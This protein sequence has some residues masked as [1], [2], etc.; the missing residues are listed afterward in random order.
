MHD[1]VYLSDFCLLSVFSL[2]TSF[3]P[4]RSLTL[5]P[6][7]YHLRAFALVSF[8]AWNTLFQDLYSASSSSS[9]RSQCHLL[10]WALCGIPLQVILHLPPQS[11]IRDLISFTPLVSVCHDHVYFLVFSLNIFPLSPSL[12]PRRQIKEGRNPCLTVHSCY[13][14]PGK[15]PRKGIFVG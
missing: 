12:V 10:R 11:F 4:H 13:L 8:F 5:R 15:C 9:C 3:K 2:P 7:R 1:L 14:G 6:G